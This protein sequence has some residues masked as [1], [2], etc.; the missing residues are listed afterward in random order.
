MRLTLL[1]TGASGHVGRGLAKH[2]AVQG[3]N[4]IL[5]GRDSERLDSVAKECRDAGV[6][7]HTH[8]FDLADTEAIISFAANLE[9]ESITVDWLVN[10]AA[11]VTSKPIRESDPAS[12]ALQV[13]ANVRGTMV[14]TRLLLPKLAQSE[15]GAIVNISSLAG[16][17]ANPG[18]TVYSVTKSAM[19]AFSEALRM[20]LGGAPYVVN[21]ALSS[22]AQG[23]QPEPGRVTT[24]EIARR[25]E[26]AVDRRQ[27][28]VYFS[29][30]TKYLMKLYAAFPGLKVWRKPHRPPGA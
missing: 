30:Q 9:N 29:W 2:F 12:I 18:Q 1:I 7:V 28:E 20:E 23:E 22:V 25:V 17:K 6:V 16:Y 21:V 10:N 3:H 8:T 13:D 5:V 24:A 11:D 19:N 15:R 14:L 4:L 27:P 26:I